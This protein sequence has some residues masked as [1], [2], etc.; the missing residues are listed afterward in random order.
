M[1]RLRRMAVFARV[2][3]ARSI[4][5]AARELGMSPSAVSQQLRA[6]ERE[7]AVVLLHRSTRRL[8]LSEAGQVFY[9]GCAAMTLAARQAEIRLAE[10]RD[11]LVG[12]LRVAA[13]AG[14]AARHLAA[15][16]TLLKAHPR[17]RLRLF[18]DD[19]RIDLIESRIDLAIRVA[20]PQRMLDS[21][22]V[23]RPLADLQE[24]LIAA[25]GYL[26]QRGT[27]ADAEALA[28]HE[29]LLL[30]PLG[31]PQF[32]DLTGPQEQVVRIRLDG[33]VAGNSAEAL[34]ARRTRH[35]P[36]DHE[37]R[38]GGRSCRRPPAAAV[39]GLAA[40]RPDRLRDDAAPRCPAG[41]GVA[42]DRSLAGIAAGRL[43]RP[44]PG[45]D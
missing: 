24:V 23:A 25:P 5:A 18:A 14:L 28:R 29:W 6:L 37:P 35:L 42:R 43:S 36:H 10:L 40:A 11:E 21:S 9:E 3:E 8:T 34:G 17:L 7:L 41:Q 30:T 22:L 2:V 33:R 31:E 1:D 27:P 20:H 45:N 16:A 13:P 15:L 26:A 38:T 4:S 12:E 19:E 44:G 32:L 39:A